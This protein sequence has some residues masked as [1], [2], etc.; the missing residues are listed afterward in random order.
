MRR[1]PVE[2]APLVASTVPEEPEDPEEPEE[3]A[4]PDD[5]EEP[6]ELVAV[7]PEPDDAALVLAS[8][9]GDAPPDDAAAR[10]AA[11]PV[12]GDPVPAELEPSE[13]HPAVSSAATAS[14]APASEACRIR[15]ASVMS[16]KSS[17]S[18]NAPTRTHLVAWRLIAGKIGEK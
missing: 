3:P 14:V 11:A 12:A 13:L 4:E 7:E 5:P 10:V 15:G 1:S 8:A 17:L 6:A 9:S 2:H 18:V 16:V